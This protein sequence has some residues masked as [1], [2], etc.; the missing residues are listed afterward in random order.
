MKRI[1]H[2]LTVVCLCVI[3]HATAQDILATSL[4]TSS[5]AG[6]VGD[7]TLTMEMQGNPVE[8]SL[9]VADVEGKMGAMVIVPML[10]NA[11]VA[12]EMEK[13]DDALKMAY[14]VEFGGQ[15]MNL[16]L[17]LT[18]A[19][20]KVSGRL[21]DDQGLFAVDVAGA[22]PGAAAPAAV[23]LKPSE[24]DTSAMG[25]YIGSWDLSMQIGGNP[26]NVTLQ[27]LDLD[28]KVTALFQSRFNPQPENI[29]RISLSEEG[30][31]LS[32]DTVVGGQSAP[33]DV[34]ITKASETLEGTLSAMGGALKADFIGARVDTDLLAVLEQAD[35]SGTRRSRGG[36]TR[37]AD[38][39][40][41]GNEIRVRYTALKDDSDALATLGLIE[42]G[43]VFMYPDGRTIKI[44]SD[45]DLV[46]GDVILKT[47][48]AGP[49]Y[50][51]VYGLWLKKTAEGWVLVAN[52]HA[53]ILG[54]QYEPSAD[55]AEF[56]V[57]YALTDADAG[58][59]AVDLD[60][61]DGGG[62]LTIRW[63]EHVWTA[64]FRLGENTIV[65]SE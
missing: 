14:E 13:T 40:L 18:L 16:M 61:R 35:A 5:A 38:L 63:R 11:L 32:F 51:G 21:E 44:L 34:F 12:T 29:Y 56:P 46:F 41:D 65:A 9:T 33:M 49:A 15:I 31:R 3:G 28:G 55:V 1:V 4:D 27:F 23:E 30:A 53:D 64:E 25:S 20:E 43:E 42:A 22:R 37:Q 17:S 7:W 52:Q 2:W 57:Q 45:S 54:S 60:E 48:N 62:V 26:F 10:P 59:M 47:E 6:F 58:P 24:L 19:D 36:G 39:K 50:P 8:V